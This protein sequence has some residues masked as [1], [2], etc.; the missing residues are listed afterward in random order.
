M[1][2]QVYKV[3]SQRSDG[4]MSAVWRSYADFQL[5]DADM[6]RIGAV[7]AADNV[8]LPAHAWFT[9]SAAP[10]LAALPTISATQA[11]TSTASAAA[12]ESKGSDSPPA[13]VGPGEDH[14][15]VRPG[16]DRVH[17]A[18]DAAGKSALQS[19]IGASPS[20]GDYVSLTTGLLDAYLCDLLA[21]GARASATTEFRA[22]MLPNERA[23]WPSSVGPIDLQK[24]DLPHASSYTEW[25]YYNT[26]F[27]DAEGN[28]FSAF[29]AFFRVLRSFDKATGKR[30][31]AHALNWA[32]TDV[33]NEAYVPTVL[34][35]KGSPAMIREQL[36]DERV[37]RDSRLRSAYIEILDKGNVPLPDRM[38]EMD[39]VVNDSVFHI[40]FQAASVHKTRSGAYRLVAKSLD[41]KT[42]IDFKLT[43]TKP[44][45]RHGLNG[46]VKGHDADDMFY[47][48]VTRCS[49]SGS[50]TVDGTTKAVAAGQGWYDHEFGGYRKEDDESI[51]MDYAWDWAAVQLENGWDIS[52]ATLCDPRSKTVKVMEKRAIVVD[53][54]GV[55]HSPKDLEFTR[56]NMW[57]S[58]RTFN[59]YPT[60][61][62]IRIPSMDIDLG[63]VSPFPD[64]ECVTLIAKPGFWEGRM[65][66][67]GVFGGKD[68]SGVG[69]VE[70]NGFTPLSDL[71]SFFRRVGEATRDAV[72]EV[73]PDNPT[74]E[75]GLMLLASPETAHFMDDVDMSVIEEGIIKPV[76]HITDVGGKSWR[77]YGALACMEV[78]GG[79]CRDY[80][81]WLSMPEFMHVGSL[82]ID[83]IQ[84]KSEKRR[85]VPCTH[86]IYGDE[87]AINAGTAAYFM[88]QQMLQTK[89]LDDKTMRRVYDY[90]FGA[91]RGGHGGQA[92]DI[93][94]LS[95][96][97]D[98]CIATGNMDLPERRLLAVHRL[99]TAVPAG[100]LAR[101]GALAGGG[102]EEQ[103]DA[104]GRYFESVGIAF[105][106]M[107]DVLNLEG[108]TTTDA[109]KTKGMELKVVG[110]DVYDGKAT[111]PVVKAIK[112]LSHDEMASTWAEIKRIGAV[113]A[114]KAKITS[115]RDAVNAVIKTLTNCGAIEASRTQAEQLVE[116]A[117]RE[118]DAVV[119]D[120]FAKIML[121]S[122]GAFVTDRRH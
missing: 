84:D 15:I 50:F 53:P 1:S 6:E 85:G 101:M 116:Q 103:I 91:L 76:R 77:S 104:V 109:D 22:F 8:T 65:T 25:W 120:S 115:E 14:P 26:H 114:G 92:L 73:Y 90:F 68:T 54:H 38:F 88:S 118:L 82:I 11:V 79:D 71:S 18:A 72:R 41:G 61:Y 121:R 13:P 57:T 74:P 97:M 17:A 94:G 42:G 39:P 24:H 44:A 47:Y 106:I 108:L 36:K 49:L 62:R 93:H 21:L 122:F 112:L 4:G 51:P 111:Y 89:K 75:Q 107:D 31:Y 45:V 7:S 43:P 40:D 60:Q 81:R 19:A 102:S 110:E 29:V 63:L 2:S 48:L 3:S 35:D 16:T 58:V 98:E 55:R 27:S 78:V 95:Y 23:D 33:G 66:V 56:E 117:W 119:P 99:K 34:L 30:D 52:V 64:Q 80:R 28:D 59:V 70:C 105:Q 100:C 96:I 86:L 9:M 69:Y 67:S 5:L 12:L 87:V 113:P 46:V 10:Q 83:D 37:I 20:M 32:L